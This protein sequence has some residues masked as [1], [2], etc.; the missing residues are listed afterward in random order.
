MNREKFI[1]AV[2]ATVRDD[3]NTDQKMVFSADVFGSE[4]R[5]WEHITA[6]GDCLEQAVG[7][8]YDM[9]IGDIK[10]FDS[11][12]AKIEIGAIATPWVHDD[13]LTECQRYH[14]DGPGYKR[15]LW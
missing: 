7:N 1:A 2:K 10:W 8:F 3:V 15:M 9:V 14:N 4:A 11:R 12:T 13:S 6:E 5:G